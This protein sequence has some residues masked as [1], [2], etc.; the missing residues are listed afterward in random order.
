MLSSAD[1][2]R[3]A[4]IL[5][6]L[7]SGAVD[8]SLFAELRQLNTAQAQRKAERD[9]AVSK[10]AQTIAELDIS[11]QELVSLY[12]EKAVRDW[13]LAH[14]PAAAPS[15]YR[16]V[17]VA[18]LARG[19]RTSKSGTVLLEVAN[20]AGKGLPARF[21]R[22]QT[23]PPFVPAAFKALLHTA[24]TGFEEKLAEHYTVEGKAYFGTPEGALDLAR[25]V[26]FVK[27]RKERPK[28]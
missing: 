6:A 13:V 22:G 12:P 20:A 5:Q 1:L 18:G 11:L 21:Y 7:A 14:Y 28:G 2:E 27:V 15:S 25:F 24:G 4:A 17:K 3:K 19:P 16:A 26:R 9:A 8:E 23:L 10:L